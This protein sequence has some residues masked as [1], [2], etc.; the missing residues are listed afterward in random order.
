MFGRIQSS[1]KRI[2]V[3]QETQLQDSYKLNT[4]SGPGR[5][6]YK[7]IFV[8]Q[9]PVL[10]R[11]NLYRMKLYKTLCR[12]PR[13]LAFVDK[14]VSPIQFTVFFR[15]FGAPEGRKVGSLKRRARSQLVR[16]EMKSLRAVVARKTFPQV[17]MYKAH[18]A[19]T[20]VGS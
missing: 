18:H 1:T 20:T 10:H 17:K 6:S 15:F 13:T 11:K 7:T 19:R 16:W 14:M 4:F 9:L 3:S 12:G 2:L 5:N 8:L